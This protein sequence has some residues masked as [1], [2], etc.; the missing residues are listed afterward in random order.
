MAV[1]DEKKT[2]AATGRRQFLLT[3]SLAGTALAPER[4]AAAPGITGNIQDYGPATYVI[5]D[6]SAVADTE[7]GKVVGYIRNGIRIFKGIP[8]A[9]IHSPEGRWVRAAKTRAG[10]GLCVTYPG[11]DCLRVNIWTPGLDNKKRQV[12]FWV[13]GGA[14]NNGSSMMSA[15]MDGGNLARHVATWWWS[16]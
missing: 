11:E 13:H 14:Y 3:A 8:Y 12:L 9:E 10:S 6:T 5:D 2:V 1:Q 7:S 15:F 16:A 4:A